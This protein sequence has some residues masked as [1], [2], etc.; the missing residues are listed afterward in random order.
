MRTTKAL[1]TALW[2][3]LAV[4][5]TPVGWAEVTASGPSGFSLKVETT[6]A[7]TPADAYSHFMQI[8]RWWDP[9][10]T[11]SGDAAN[12]ALSAKV[13]GCFCETLPGGGFVKHMDVVYAAPGQAVRLLGGLGPLQG[14]GASGALTFAFKADGAITRVTV[15]YVVSGFAPGAGLAPIAQP[16]EG[17]LTE[18]MARFKRFT[19]TG[20][21]TA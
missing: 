4:A 6:I 15:T 21:P 18:Q 2:G 19:E 13:G 14:M 12:L 8:G 20:K 11:Y 10:H 3:L 16:V 7:G 5:A 17:V 1:S 9:A